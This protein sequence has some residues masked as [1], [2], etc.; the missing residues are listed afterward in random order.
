[1]C[2]YIY[3]HDKDV[4]AYIHMRSYEDIYIEDIGYM[5]IHMYIDMSIVSPSYHGFSGTSFCVTM[6]GGNDSLRQ[7]VL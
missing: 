4:Y 3:I 1:M 2:I 6:H 7:H 5:C